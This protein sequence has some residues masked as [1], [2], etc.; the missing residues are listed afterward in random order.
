MIREITIV[1]QQ[2]TKNYR[3]GL[4]LESGTIALIKVEYLTFT[5]D[6]FSHYC[7]YNEAGKL[8]FSIEPS[9]P[10]DVEYL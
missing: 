6:P 8:L 9:C 7:G 5:G 4:E 1:N 3:L 2:G 10:C